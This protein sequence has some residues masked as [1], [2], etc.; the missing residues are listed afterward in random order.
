MDKERV[1]AA[2]AELQSRQR[3]RKAFNP[4]ALCHAK[5]LPYVQAAT[6]RNVVRCSRRAGKTTGTAIKLLRLAL[7]EPYANTYYVTTSLKHSRRLVWP[8]LGKLNKHFQL[9]G[10]T[11]ETEAFMHFP[12]LPEA[13]AH[14]PGWCK[15][16]G[17]D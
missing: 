5:Q 11:N 10:V 14:L 2:A 3:R 7:S 12:Q 4:R 13:P 16:R 1:A 17:A 9:G 15:G 6:K 8:T